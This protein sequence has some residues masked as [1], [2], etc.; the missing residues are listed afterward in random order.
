VEVV[1]PPLGE[2]ISD[3]AISQIFKKAGDSVALDEPVAQIETDKVTIDVP[4]P[5]AGVVSEILVSVDDTVVV[6]Q[7]VVV[8]DSEG[9]G[10]PAAAGATAAGAP[11]AATAPAAAAAPGRAP[12][13]RFPPRMSA[14]GQRLSEMPRGAQAAAPAAPPQPTPPPPPPVKQAGSAA[15]ATPSSGAAITV[16][17]IG[18]VVSTRLD[19]MPP[20]LA[21]SDEELELVN[22][23]GAA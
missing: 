16:A 11:A 9:A 15:A 13:I 21:I 20:G 14:E 1:I 2:S 5:A 6:G 4:S 23:G 17:S 3:G 22:L 7:A 18:D 19:A 8:L 12:G 10:A